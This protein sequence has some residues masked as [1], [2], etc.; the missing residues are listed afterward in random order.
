MLREFN[1]LKYTNTCS[2]H[3]N[4]MLKF[5]TSRTICCHDVQVKNYNYNLKFMFQNKN[6][7]LFNRILSPKLKLLNEK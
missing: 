5:K 6:N 2:F 3:M 1:G 4:K 7:A